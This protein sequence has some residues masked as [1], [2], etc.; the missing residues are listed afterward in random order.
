MS[1]YSPH[2]ADS[3]HHIDYITLKYDLG[4]YAT[5]LMKCKF[6]NTCRC[7][8]IFVN[9]P[10]EFRHR[11]M[12]IMSKMPQ[13]GPTNRPPSCLKMTRIQP[14]FS[15]IN[16]SL[17]ACPPKPCACRGIC[18]LVFIRAVTLSC[19]RKRFMSLWQTGAMTNHN[20]DVPDLVFL[21]LFL[22]TDILSPR[23]IQP[24]YL[25]SRPSAARMLSL[26]QPRCL[27]CCQ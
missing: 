18:V 23:L 15:L 25:S 3:L 1:L 27:S 4:N 8:F 19:P 14:K 5:R 20:V 16:V 10:P 13:T 26:T 11:L 24:S 12:P 17:T 2:A 22:A 9:R 21:H 6:I 7:Y